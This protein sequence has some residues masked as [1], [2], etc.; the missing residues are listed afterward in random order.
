MKKAAI[1]GLGDI[2]SIHYNAIRAD[3]DIRLVAVCDTDREKEKTAGEYQVPFY[4]DYHE[5]LRR[6]KPD[7]VHLCLPHYLHYPVAKDCAEAHVNIF[8]EKPEAVSAE[9]AEAFCE[10]SDSHP[11]IHIGICLQNRRNE[12]TEALKDILESGRYGRT[13]GV[14]GSVFWYR[15]REYYGVKPW[16]GKWETAGSGCMM[17]Q[18]IHTLDL[19][20]WLCGSV[21]NVRALVGQTLA[22][23]IEVEDTVAAHLEFQNGVSGYFTATNANYKNEAVQLNVQTEKAEFRIRDNKL[24]CMDEEG[25]ETLICEDD[26]LPGT[27]FYYG[28]SHAKIISEFYRDLETGERHFI[29]VRQGSE[30]IKI[31]A[32]ILT[33]GREG[34]NVSVK[35]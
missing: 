12:T 6:E 4:T 28:A 32:A 19:M 24:Y 22:Y 11:E 23:G 30:V 26:T 18:S 27:K 33:A 35:Q 21:E 9:Q 14:R 29:T 2:S 5:M 17:N 3:S 15:P 8:C 13:I 25:K 20:T 16:R 31:I 34:R 10:L 1:I 7:C